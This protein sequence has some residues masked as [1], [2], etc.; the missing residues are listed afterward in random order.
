[1]IGIYIQQDK[2]CN[3]LAPAEDP[4]EEK[5]TAFLLAFIRAH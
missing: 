4:P 1:M 3:F 5:N 2:K